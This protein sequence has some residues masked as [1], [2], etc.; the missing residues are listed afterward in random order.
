MIHHISLRNKWIPVAILAFGFC[1]GTAAQEHAKPAVPKVQQHGQQAAPKNGEQAQAGST[2]ELAEASREAAG[3]DETAEFKRS[4]A[5]RWPVSWLVRVTGMGPITAYWF[6]IGIDF[7]VIAIL[8]FLFVKAFLPGAFRARTESIRKSVDEA[9]RASELAQK[10][11]SDIEARLSKLDGEIAAMRTA[12]ETEAK[13]EEERIRAA[14]E[15]DKKKIVEA[16]EQEIAAA[17]NLAR[18]DLKAYVAELAVTLAEKRIRINAE[19]DE[20]LVRSFVDELG[21]N[22]Q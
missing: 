14:A 11:L 17:A 18:R 16:A 13:G 4:A 9:R 12:A 20:E 8:I 6:S 10:R 1:V 7:L 3:E 19:T 15:Q 2:D 22:G 5:K 21:K